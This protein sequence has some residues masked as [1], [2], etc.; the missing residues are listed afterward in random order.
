M[1]ENY[2]D[3][4]KADEFDR[5]FGALAIGKNPTPGHNRYMV[6]NW[7]FSAII[8]QGKPEQ[9]QQSLHNHN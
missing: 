5:L 6:L 9:I 4:A 7:D 3:V 2:Y 1:L 8:P